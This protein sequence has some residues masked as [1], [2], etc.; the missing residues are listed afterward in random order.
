MNGEQ[1]FLTEQ[2]DELQEI[3]RMLGGD[4]SVDDKEAISKVLAKEFM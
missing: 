1:A 4:A 3:L 2:V